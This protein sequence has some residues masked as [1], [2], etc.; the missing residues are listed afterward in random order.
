MGVK[1]VVRDAKVNKP[2][3][4]VFVKVIGIDSNV[5]TNS[6]GEFWRLL[7]N[8]KYDITFEA[9][10][11]YKKTL[12][13]ITVD[14][15]SRK[16]AKLIDVSLIPLQL[17][18]NKTINYALKP[19]KE[20]VDF[21][22][23]QDFDDEQLSKNPYIKLHL[24]K[25]DFVTKPEFKHHNQFELQN[26]LEKYNKMYPNLTRLY[27]V[28]NSAQNRPILVLEISDRPGEHEPGEPEFKYVGNIHGNEVVGRELLL[29]FI[30][31][32]LENYHRN[33]TI[34][35][36]VD[37][38][39]I[40]VMPTANPDGYEKSVVGDCDT[41]TGRRNARGVDLN[42]NFP[43]RFRHDRRFRRYQPETRALMKWIKAYPFVLSISFH[44]GALVANYP[45][46]GN[47]ENRDHEYTPT[48]DDRM[49]RHL[50]LTYARVR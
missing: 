20:H 49:F 42:R 38:T 11:Y 34:R 18:T 13:G 7:L 28:G 12:H 10:G 40:H 27:S 36:I 39:R 41:E 16:N 4:N 47:L 50:A 48:P 30:Q 2:I 32:L 43:D 3:E 23:L 37:N 29:L 24:L 1:G 5:T 22:D 25:R 21:D 26:F 45:F 14:N 8:G 15:L 44:G 46:D 33:E 19:N 9:S 35:W 17:S 6:R 31:S